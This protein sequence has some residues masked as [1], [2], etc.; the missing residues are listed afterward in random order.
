MVKHALIVFTLIM[1][2][3]MSVISAQ[4][5]SIDDTQIIDQLKQPTQTLTQQ[6]LKLSQTTSCAALETTLESYL[7]KHRNSR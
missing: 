5:T 2:T 6:D 7:N 4:T 3:Q 1:S